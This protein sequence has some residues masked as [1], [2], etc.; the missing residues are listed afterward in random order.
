MLGG[1]GNGGGAAAQTGVVE[2]LAATDDGAVSD[3]ASGAQDDSQSNGSGVDEGADAGE[4]PPDEPEQP[5]DEPTATPTVTPAP[6]DDP[7]P[8][9]GDPCPFCPEDVDDLA[10]PPTAT[11]D[12][13]C[14]FCPDE[15][16]GLQI[17]PTPIVPCALC[18][19]GDIMIDLPELEFEDTLVKHCG[20]WVMMSAELNRNAEIWVEYTKGGDDLETAHEFGTSFQEFEN[21]AWGWF[22]DWGWIYPYSYTFHAEDAEGNHISWY[23]AHAQGC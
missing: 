19:N 10:V 16:D 9:P 22:G 13:P 8:E 17:A 1:R 3:G 6:E 18:L 5:A 23:E 15:I 12:D 11:P 7:D 14:P 2:Q 4:E 20:G 21:G